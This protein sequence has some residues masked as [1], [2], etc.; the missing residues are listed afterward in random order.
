[1]CVHVAAGK[2]IVVRLLLVCKYA[3]QKVKDLAECGGLGASCPSSFNC[4]YHVCVCVCV[5][6]CAC[7]RTSNGALEGQSQKLEDAGE[8]EGVPQR[9]P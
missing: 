3:N 2:V 4:C 5:C 8:G 7:V 1:M 9:V 6:V